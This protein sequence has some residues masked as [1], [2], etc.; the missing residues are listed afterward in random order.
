MEAHKFDPNTGEDEMA[1]ARRFAGAAGRRRSRSEKSGEL[2]QGRPQ[3]GLSLRLRQEVQALPRP[4][5]LRHARR[6]RRSA[7]PRLLV[8][9]E[10]IRRSK[11]LRR[12]L[13][14]GYRK[15]GRRTVY[16]A[17]DQRLSNEFA[18]TDGWRRRLDR[19]AAA[20]A[21]AAAASV[22]DGFSGGRAW[23]PVGSASGFACLGAVH[24][25]LLR[26][27]FLDRLR[28]GA[29]RWPSCWRRR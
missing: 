3:R 17:A 9:N 22:T 1:F 21:G 24:A 14:A 29:W 5:R 26:H 28:H 13:M 7:K 12:A 25:W 4:L 6:R 16:C 15:S 19:G 10:I 8:T 11:R 27:R 20:C 18:G 23:W 2:G